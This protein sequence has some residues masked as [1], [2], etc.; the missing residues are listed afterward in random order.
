MEK[1]PNPFRGE[2]G[3]QLGKACL[4]LRP[5]FTRLVAAEAEIG[6]LVCLLDRV[7]AGDVRLGEM[8]ALFWHSLE[9]EDMKREELEEAILAAGVAACLTPCRQLL[10]AIFKGQGC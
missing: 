1:H 4:R 5:T 9:A 3:L 10:L 6:S 7:S 2:V 8:A